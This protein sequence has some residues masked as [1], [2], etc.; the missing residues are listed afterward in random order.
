MRMLSPTCKTPRESA[1]RQRG[2]VASGGVAFLLVLLGLV[3]PAPGQTLRL[4]ALDLYLTGRL[5]VGYESNIDGAYPE[6]EDPIYEKGDFY[7][8]PGLTL[9]ADPVRMR[10]STTLNIGAAFEYMDYL[11]RDDEDTELYNVNVD[12][13]TVLPRITFMGH[14]MASHEIESEQDSSYRPGGS[15]TDPMQTLEASVMLNY[16]LGKLRVETHADHTIE[17]HDKEEYKPDNQDETTL[18]GGVFWDVFSWGSLYYSWENVV[19]EFVETDEETDETTQNFGIS[20]AIPLSWLRHPKISYSFGFEYEEVETQ[21]GGKDDPTWEPTHTITVMDEFQLSKS[22][23]LSFSATWEDTWTDDKVS[24]SNT[25]DEDDEVTFE[26]SVLLSHE[27]SPRV[28]HSLS[29]TQE[30]RDTFGSVTDTETTTYAYALGVKDILFYGLNAGFSAEY[31]L[32]TPLGSDEPTERT[33]SMEVSASHS[34]QLSRRL[35]RSLS[36][37][38]SW[39]NTNFH[40]DGALEEHVVTYGL[41][42]QF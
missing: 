38:Y 22:L 19:T 12:F 11:E 1:W 7:W 3:R 8:S 41:D 28:Q 4:G 26:Y 5:E 9:Q 16:S 37:T 33:T 40:H 13:Q 24:L 14:G 32:S 2:V 30:P 20:G 23:L 31:E 21:D 17:R 27:I 10:P 25:S 36:Y 42:Y 6:E 34:R 35:S 29:F 18:F 39:E 15:K